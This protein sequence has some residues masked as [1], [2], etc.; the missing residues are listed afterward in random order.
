[1]FIKVNVDRP[2]TSKDELSLRPHDIIR[3]DSTIYAD[4]KGYWRGALLDMDT[5][6]QVKFGIIPSKTALEEEY[7]LRRHTDV[8]PAAL[9]AALPTGA[10]G[11]ADRE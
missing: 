1:M 3:V 9:L 6:R 5:G 7:C 11:T 8:T 10:D 2:S 4:R